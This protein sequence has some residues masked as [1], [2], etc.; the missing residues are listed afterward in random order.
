MA[1]AAG[2]PLSGEVFGRLFTDWVA[3][4]VLSLDGTDMEL[5][6]GAVLVASAVATLLATVVLL[7]RSKARS[8]G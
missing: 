2:I 3:L 5:A 1:E 7:R 6:K 8:A 4:A